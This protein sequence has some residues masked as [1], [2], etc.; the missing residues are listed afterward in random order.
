MKISLEK[1]DALAKKTLSEKRY[2]HTVCVVK[3]ARNLAEIYGCD[4]YKAMVAAWLHDICKEQ[5]FDEQL[6]LLTK[7][8]I[9][10]DSVQ[11][12]QPKTWHGMAACG[13]MKEQLRIDDPEILQA[14][15]Y[16][17]T[18]C[19]QMRVLDEVIYLADLTSEERDYPDAEK[20]RHM[21]ETDRTLAMREAMKFAVRD[22]AE[23][24]LGIS[25]ETFEAYN[26]YVQ[27]QV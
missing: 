22:L 21:A 24:G 17:T 3:Q 19:G 13:F 9:I 12:N 1:L 20:F 15:R 8:G 11:K 18:G 25:L 2:H 26:F 7:F 5:K 10:L 4:P 27:T 16:H 6:Q 23:R 14:V